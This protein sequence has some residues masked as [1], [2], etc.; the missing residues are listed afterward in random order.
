MQSNTKIFLI[1]NTGVGNLI[2]DSYE[3]ENIMQQNH[4]SKT[5]EKKQHKNNN[6]KISSLYKN[7]LNAKKNIIYFV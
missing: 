6:K 5:R 1:K 2:V 4:K 7:E 3:R